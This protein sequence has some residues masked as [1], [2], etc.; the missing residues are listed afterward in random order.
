[1]PEGDVPEHHP[2]WHWELIP[3]AASSLPSVAPLTLTTPY[4]C[5]FSNWT[6]PKYEENS[7]ESFRVTFVQ[8]IGDMEVKQLLNGTLRP[9]DAKFE[10]RNNALFLALLKI[11]NAS[12]SQSAKNILSQCV[13]HDSDGLWLW[14][15]MEECHELPIY[16]HQSALLAELQAFTMDPQDNDSRPVHGEAKDLHQEDDAVGAR[17]D[18]ASS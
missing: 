7:W 15:Y 13:G 2:G 8:G 14:R 18:V 5:D 12:A 17:G 11:L 3:V 1:V 9:G 4:K 10:S 6:L 16:S